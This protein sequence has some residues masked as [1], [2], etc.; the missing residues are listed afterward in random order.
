M[1]L[2]TAIIGLAAVAALLGWL[3]FFIVPEIAWQASRGSVATGWAAIG[4]AWPVYITAGV[5]FGLLSLM[6]GLTIG[7]TARE[8]DL[9]VRTAQA[10]DRG[11][12]AENR[13]QT[14]TQDAQ[15]AVSA[16]RAELQRQ[17]QQ[18]RELVA[19][20]KA[21]RAAADREAERAQT[22][23]AELERELARTT[24][25][26]DGA[27]AAMQRAKRREKERQQNVMANSN[28]D[29]ADSGV[30]PGLPHWLND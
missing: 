18:A 12:Q 28:R 26:L 21:A 16:E 13:A 15:A 20:A 6:V 2:T 19:A 14:A 27:R 1:R 23:V 22:R 30:D 5:L 11:A 17:Q 9:A 25:R 24:R 3:H 7:E 10:E 8:R 4:S 29:R